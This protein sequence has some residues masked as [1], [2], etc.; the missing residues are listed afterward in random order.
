MKNTILF[1][2]IFFITSINLFAQSKAGELKIEP[3]TF[4]TA[5]GQKV[6]AERGFVSVPENRQNPKSRLIQIAFIRFKS[7]SPNPKSPIVYL[8]GGPSS[9][10]IGAARSSRFSMFMALREVADVIAL[11]QRGVGQS[12]PNLN[13]I[14]FVDLP[15]DKPA[16]ENDYLQNVLDKSKLCAKYWTEQRVDL[17][18]YNTNENAD[19]IEDLRK[20]IG[21]AKINLLGISYGTHLGLTVLKRH[22]ENIEKAILAGVEGLDDTYKLPSNIQSQ[23]K[24]IEQE[25]KTDTELGAKIPDLLALMKK[26]FD[27]VEKNPETVEFTDSQSQKKVKVTI[28]KFDLQLLTAIGMGDTNFISNLPALFYA[29]DKGN[30]SFIAPQVAGFRKRGIGSAMAFMMDCASGISKDRFGRIEREKENTLLGAIID[31]P[32]PKI[33]EAWNQTDLGEKFRSP[34][35]SNV[36]TLFISGTLDGRTPVS[37][38]E[39]VRKGFSKSQHLIIERAGHSDDLLISSPKIAETMVAFLKGDK[40]NPKITLPS[41]KWRKF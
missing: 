18:G 39:I 27:R 30:F 8:A 7:T 15:F 1:L 21:A 38:A 6:E 35:K 10:G 34:L 4:E 23:L 13:C 29:M 20:A 14:N 25:F 17:T 26:V 9:S 24:V 16:N 3:F 37:N 28:G 11:D 22:G 19:D 33:C 5:N 32:F 2:A 41:L 31:F 36:P 40:I 12:K